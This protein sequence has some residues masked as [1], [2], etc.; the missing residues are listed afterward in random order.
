MDGAPADNP[1]RPRTR[2]IVA[3]TLLITDAAWRTLVDHAYVL[4]YVRGEITP[5]GISHYLRALSQQAFLDARHKDMQRTAQ[6]SAGLEP[7]MQHKLDLHIETIVKLAYT[8]RHFGIA[9]FRSQRPIIEGRRRTL[10]QGAMNVSDTM[11]VSPVLE[12][13]GLRWLIPLGI[14]PN[15]PFNLYALPSR[16][17]ARAKKRKLASENVYTIYGY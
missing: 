12:A 7:A 15:A 14:I 8:A 2:L 4:G 9:P 3:R 10:H 16:A 1:P 11:L 13:I 5:K 6:W 17:K